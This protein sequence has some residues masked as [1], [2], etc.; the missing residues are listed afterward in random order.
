MKPLSLFICLF[1]IFNG[2]SHAQLTNTRAGE[3][4]DA[5]AWSSSTIP[6]SDDDVVLYFDIV[7]DVDAWCH[8]L[9]LN[10]HH[11][12][13]A[14]GVHFTISG[15]GNSGDTLLTR[16]AIVDSTAVPGQD[17][18]ETIDFIYD[19]LQRNIATTTIYYENGGITYRSVSAFFYSGSS[20]L[21]YKTFGYSYNY[22]SGDSSYAE[23]THYYTYQNGRV[24][25]DSGD[26]AVG[27]YQ[28]LPNSIITEYIYTG[29]SYVSTDTFN[30]Q[31]DANSNI[32]LQ[33]NAARQDSFRYVYD[34]HPNPF[35]HTW[36]NKAYPVYQMETF[37]E[38][39]IAGNNALEVDQYEGPQHYHTGM[40][41]QYN[42]N[43]Y[44]AIIWGYDPEDPYS[45]GKAVYFYGH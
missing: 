10:G 34:T 16:F 43:G 3:W 11:A 2:T 42:S 27:H 1:F 8:S 5:T 21:P 32:L 22:F 7:I 15:T 35:Y 29:S 18:T 39:V 23:Y 40:I 17:T 25:T 28:Y 14:P 30:V 9:H 45:S 26:E 6:T 24:V 38:E 37:P 33:T 19:S 20:Q 13:V 31:Y 4:S 12:T 36:R 44:P 41:Y